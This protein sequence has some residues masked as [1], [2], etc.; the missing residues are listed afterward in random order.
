M[1]PSTA[2]AP[3]APA[4]SSRAGNKFRA[5]Q[6]ARVAKNFKPSSKST[7]PAGQWTM[8]DRIKKQ[9]STWSALSEKAPPRSSLRRDMRTLY[10]GDEVHE[11]MAAEA[12]MQLDDGDDVT[13]WGRWR[14]ERALARATDGI[15]ENHMFRTAGLLAEARRAQRNLLLFPDPAVSVDAPDSE[16]EDALEDAEHLARARRRHR[17]GDHTSCNPTTTVDDMDDA[18][19][20]LLCDDPAMYI[21]SFSFSAYT[22]T[23]S[24][25]PKT[26]KASWTWSVGSKLLECFGKTGLAH[27]FGDNMPHLSGYPDDQPV[28]VSTEEDVARGPLVG[29]VGSLP[30]LAR[31]GCDYC[32]HSRPLGRDNPAS[33]GGILFYTVFNVWYRGQENN[34]RMDPVSLAKPRDVSRYCVLSFQSIKFYQIKR[35]YIFT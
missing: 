34:G 19:A 1:S 31:L 5:Q 29:L 20:D 26:S 24:T 23:F 7:T 4:S 22:Y 33:I 2:I 17:A 14:A 9:L 18:A 15:G 16:A 12:L 13:A 6:S 21:S 28:V 8:P 27:V 11:M 25:L 10:W 32:I 3:S 30:H 35:K